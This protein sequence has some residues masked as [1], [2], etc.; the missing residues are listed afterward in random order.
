MKRLLEKWKS[1][2][3]IVTLILTVCFSQYHNVYAAMTSL[4]TNGQWVRNE[5]FDSGEYK[6]YSLTLAQDS[7]V[8]I[9]IIS[10]QSM[11][12]KFM[13]AD[14][15]DVSSSSF[16][17]SR[18]TP[19]SR[20]IEEYLSAGSYY[21]RLEN[22]S[23]STNDAFDIKTTVEGVVNTAEKEPNTAFANANSLSLNTEYTGVIG[24]EDEADWLCF[25]IPENGQYTFKIMGYGR[26]DYNIYNEDLTNRIISSSLFGS[27]QEPESEIKDLEMIKGKNYLQIERIESGKYIF[28]LKA[29]AHQWS[30]WVITKAATTTEEGIKTRTCSSC[31][32]QETQPIPK[33]PALAQS[34]ITSTAKNV[35]N[36]NNA[37]SRAKKFKV[38][39]RQYW[40]VGGNNPADWFKIVVPYKGKIVVDFHSANDGLTKLHLRT[41][42]GKDID[43]AASKNNVILSAGTYFV[44]VT[45][46][47]QKVN[48]NFKL[49]YTPI[50]SGPSIKRMSSSRRSVTMKFTKVRGVTGY[51]VSIATNH[52]FKKAWHFM[53]K[54]TSRKITG[55]KR[56][57]KYYVKVRAYKKYQN[58]YYYGD[59]SKVRIV[60][61]KR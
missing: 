19:D 58:R 56:N 53:L 43:Y 44:G 46:K 32:A 20:K 6:W 61:T 1:V 5:D 52:K 37:M 48:Y 28:S 3:I 42:K 57:R 21:L 16:F 25:D 27:F 23:D 13:T 36:N 2:F 50:M 47:V 60:Y 30:D 31:G 9:N 24:A 41:S 22:Y 39:K 8:K 4:D 7:Y 10:Y 33:L 38:N 18:S 15:N 51:Q 29:K 26:I 54:S 14:Y 55:L 35:P 40:T 59:F 17:G 12:S 11:Y 49:F 34:T 45:R